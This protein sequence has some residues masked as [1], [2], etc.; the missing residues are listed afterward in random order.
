MIKQVLAFILLVAASTSM[1]ADQP[2]RII[3]EPVKAAVSGQPVY[4]RATVRDDKGA[5]KAVNLYCSVSSDSAPFKVAMRASGAGAF[6]GSIPKTLIQNAGKVSYYIEAVD[7][8]EQAS[9]T[10]WYTIKLKA[11]AAKASATG[12]KKRSWKKP[13]LITAG[14]AAAVGIGVAVAGGGSDD[15]D[16][17][18]GGTTPTDGDGSG[19][20]RGN[21]TRV[22]TLSGGDPIQETYAIEL[23][24]LDGTAIS[25][26]DLHPEGPMSAVVS[27]DSFTMVGPV[28]TNGL[29]ASVNYIGTISG[30]I[31]SGR[32]T[33]GAVT[34]TGTNGTY[35][36][37]FSANKQ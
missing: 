27:S 12:E 8:L 19:I 4:I 5:A 33:G 22:F 28:S 29:T 31:I 30:S 6:I 7:S 25:S 18:N 35:S 3:H 9:E 20:Y 13:L 1:A 11:S 14:T 37:F 32:I 23:N 24:L 10:P 34:A 16:D 2:P 15:G 26:P 36:G 21:A 17:G